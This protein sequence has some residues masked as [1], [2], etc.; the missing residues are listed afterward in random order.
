MKK[1][2]V[3]IFLVLSVPSSMAVNRCGHKGTLIG[4]S[5]TAKT[6]DAKFHAMLV[7]E[8]KR[9]CCSK[10]SH[11]VIEVVKQ[12]KGPAEFQICD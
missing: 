7:K 6:F 8:G 10:K 4:G 11:S 5:D 1:L 9:N 3:L 12:G 2:L